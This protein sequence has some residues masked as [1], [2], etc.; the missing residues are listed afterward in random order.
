MSFDTFRCTI[1]VAG[2]S[3]HLQCPNTPNP[4]LQLSFHT[5]DI[6]QFDAFPPASPRRFPPEE[7]ELLCHTDSS[8]IAIREITVGTTGTR[9]PL[10]GPQPGECDRADDSFVG[11]A[12]TVAPA[13][14]VV[15]SPKRR[16]ELISM[17]RLTTFEADGNIECIPSR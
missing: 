5:L 8:G 1:R 10:I 7:K 12:G 6:I 3:H 17:W 14:V 15:E 4:N 16:S 2:N 9:G 13:V 11:F